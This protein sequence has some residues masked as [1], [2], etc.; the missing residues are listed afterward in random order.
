LIE[1]FDN[2]F[3]NRG[4]NLFCSYCFNDGHCCGVGIS[5]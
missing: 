3:Q 1:P 2:F 5:T 4:Q